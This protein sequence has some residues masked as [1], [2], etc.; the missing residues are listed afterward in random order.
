[1]SGCNQCFEV[2]LGLVD[3]RLVQGHFLC[4]CP[5]EEEKAA[6]IFGKRPRLINNH[7]EAREAV[8]AYVD[9]EN[10]QVWMIDGNYFNIVDGEAI[11][12]NP[13]DY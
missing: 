3:S 2:S 5:T 9:E 8:K 12:V 6:W 1:M 11:I 4:S 13:I 7:W 10:C